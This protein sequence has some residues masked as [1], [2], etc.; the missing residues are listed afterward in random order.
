MTEYGDC[1]SCALERRADPPPRERI[2]LDAHWRVA[3]AFATS[4]AG[5]GKP[6]VISGATIVTPGRP[7]T[8]RDELIAA[9]PIEDIEQ[10]HYF[11]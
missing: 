5:S 1:L 6:L 3:H 11:T 8:E 4:L 7:A 9:G 10:G 2:Y